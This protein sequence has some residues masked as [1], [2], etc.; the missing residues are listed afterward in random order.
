MVCTCLNRGDTLRIT[1]DIVLL[2]VIAYFIGAL[3]I[4][5]TVKNTVT[6]LVF[7]FFCVCV[8]FA[9]DL[10]QTYISQKQTSTLLLTLINESL[11]RQKIDR[12][13]YVT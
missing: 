3:L 13:R 10:E 7:L 1:P 6:V 12:R 4:Y 8:S 2:V 5:Q 11:K 9:F